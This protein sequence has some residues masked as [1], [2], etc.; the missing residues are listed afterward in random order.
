MKKYCE[1]LKKELATAKHWHED[2]VKQMD[3]GDFRDVLTGPRHL[4]NSIRAIVDESLDTIFMARV[5]WHEEKFLGQF[6]KEVVRLQMSS[7]YEIDHKSRSFIYTPNKEINFGNDLVFLPDNFHCL[8]YLDLTN[9]EL[10]ALPKGLVVQGRL[11]IGDLKVGVPDDIQ[12]NGDFY[13]VMQSFDDPRR[14]QL[15]KLKEKGQI[16]GKLSILV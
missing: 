3:L 2:Y 11:D 4:K 1:D 8:G 9:T 7:R 15:K 13:A 10:K 14:K 16:T 5:H 6:S 12:I